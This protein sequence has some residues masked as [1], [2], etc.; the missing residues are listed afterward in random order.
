MASLF[1]PLSKC[2][3]TAA[4]KP[5]AYAVVNTAFQARYKSK[6]SDSLDK[7]LE[8]KPVDALADPKESCKLVFYSPLPPDLSGLTL[9]LGN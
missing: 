9:K 3:M 8:K 7:P 1:R 5:N 4:R 2:L 6:Q